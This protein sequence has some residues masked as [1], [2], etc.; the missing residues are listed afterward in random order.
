MRLH[1]SHRPRLVGLMHDQFLHQ[2]EF[3][4][5]RFAREQFICDQPECIDIVGRMRLELLDHLRGRVGDRQPAQRAGV[6]GIFQAVLFVK[7]AAYLQGRIAFGMA[8]AFRGRE[9]QGFLASEISSGR[10]TGSVDKDAE[11]HG[12]AHR[13]QDRFLV[14]VLPGLAL[15]GGHRMPPA[16]PEEERVHAGEK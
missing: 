7:E 1:I 3:T 15:R 4:E 16:T 5:R 13:E 2:W 9:L 12:N 14:V 10:I 6:E 8:D 11:E